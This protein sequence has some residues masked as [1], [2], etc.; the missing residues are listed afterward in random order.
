LEKLDVK[1]VIFN[2]PNNKLSTLIPYVKALEDWISK[3]R[4]EK[5]WEITF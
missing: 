2:S 4:A 1:V 5:V 3:L